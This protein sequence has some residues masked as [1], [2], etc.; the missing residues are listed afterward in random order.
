M[1]RVVSNTNSMT[2]DGIPGIR[3]AQQAGSV[4]QGAGER[5]REGYGQVADE[6]RERYEMAEDLVRH[7]PA[8]SVAAAFGLGIVVGL[9]VGM[10]LRSR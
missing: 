1:V 3:F 7:N 2:F 6:A 10:A 9:V 8:Q 4:A 5:I